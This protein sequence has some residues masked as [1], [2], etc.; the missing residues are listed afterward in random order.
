MRQLVRSEMG[1][2]ASAELCRACRDATGGNPYLLV[3]LLGEFRRGGSLATEIDPE[4]VGH[5][6]PERIDEGGVATRRRLHPQAS[7]LARSVAVLG[8]QARL[9]MCAELAGMDAHIA[10]GLASAS[11]TSRCW[12]L[13]SPCASYT[14]SF[15]PRSMKICP[16]SS[17]PSFMLVPLVYCTGTGPIREPSRCTSWQLRRVATGDVVDH[18][19]G[20][21]AIGTGRRSPG[22]RRDPAQSGAG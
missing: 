10:H 4:A 16:R 19:A 7:A 21:S 1:D 12:F 9:A 22:H 6:A 2:N 20:G 3:E 17:E 8:E 13:G 18:V 14:P 15:A 5:V 11:S